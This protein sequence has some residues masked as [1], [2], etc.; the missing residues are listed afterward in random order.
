MEDLNWDALNAVHDYA[1]AQARVDAPP[2]LLLLSTSPM[3]EVLHR[4]ELPA[5]VML[6]FL[7]MGAAGKYVLAKLMADVLTEGSFPRSLFHKEHGFYPNGLAQVNEAWVT[8]HPKDADTSNLPLPSED[9]NRRE[10]LLVV[11]H[12]A[13]RSVP[14]WHPIVEQ[15]HRHVEPAPFPKE[16]DLVNV[17]GRFTGQHTKQAAPVS[18]AEFAARYPQAYACMLSMIELTKSPAGKITELVAHCMSIFDER[19]MAKMEEAFE[20]VGPERAAEILQ[21]VY[22]AHGSPTAPTVH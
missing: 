16:G 21:R 14:A 3:G 20:R 2:Q 9:P 15:P 7:S 13:A 12:T 22:A 18:V 19:G 17:S 8:E 4:A 11:V 1:L 10:V 5:E 6:K